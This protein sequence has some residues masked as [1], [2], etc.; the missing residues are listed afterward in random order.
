MP[1]SP[2]IR[3]SNS[4]RTW[5]NAPT[6][7]MTEVDQR[8]SELLIRIRNDKAATAATL[9]ALKDVEDAQT[10]LTEAQDNG[11]GTAAIQAIRAQ[12]DAQYKLASAID[13]VN[14]AT[15]RATQ[16]AEDEAA[17]FEK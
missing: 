17:A 7:S 2:G 8:V 6:I 5:A 11:G 15:Q 3:V 13:E 10:S 16:I 12:S 9:A 14:Q 1:C 4:L